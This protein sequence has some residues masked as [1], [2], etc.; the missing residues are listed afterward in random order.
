MNIEPSIMHRKITPGG[1]SLRGRIPSAVIQLVQ[2][3][4][5]FF[6]GALPDAVLNH[7]GKGENGGKDSQVNE[8]SHHAAVT[9]PEA[10][11]RQ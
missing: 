1:K 3:L 8:H 4:V 6:Q 11:G 10:K 5:D 9:Q 2:L 7:P